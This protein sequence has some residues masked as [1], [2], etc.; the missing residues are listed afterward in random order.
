MK[1]N[2]TSMNFKPHE[3]VIF[4]QT[5]KIGTHKNKTIH[6]INEFI[7]IIS[8]LGQT[9]RESAQDNQIAALF[10]EINTMTPDSQHR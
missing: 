10:E 5:M 6:S 7:C 1:E 3:C 8:R 4:A 9:C 2:A